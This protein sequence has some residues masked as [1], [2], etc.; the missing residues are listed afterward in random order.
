MERRRRWLVGVMGSGTQEHAEL[1]EPL[2]RWLGSAGYDLLTGGGGGVMAAV[3]RGF[4]EVP[5]RAGVSV[6]ILPAGPPPGY[7]NPWVDVA[8][9]T[10]LPQRGAEGAGERSRNHLNVLS[11][12]ALVVLPGGAGTR[13][14]VELAFRYRKPF[15]VYLGPAGAIEGLRRDQ[16]PAVAATQAEVE[17]FVRRQLQEIEGRG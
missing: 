15:V 10:H 1:A 9:R 12:D 16:L 17:E 3:C 5:G 7:P 13:T 4:A 6:G 11:P 8:I 2:G 14:E